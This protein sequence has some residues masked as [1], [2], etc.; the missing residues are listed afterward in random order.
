MPTVEELLS[1]VRS[2]PPGD[3]ERLRHEL[4]VM[5]TEDNPPGSDDFWRER[6]VEELAA[7]QGVAVPDTLDEIF[8]KGTDLWDDGNAFDNFVYAIYE[9]RQ[10]GNSA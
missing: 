8:G 1:A 4:E 7:L 5:A 10:A 2:L 3:R 6:T 9:R